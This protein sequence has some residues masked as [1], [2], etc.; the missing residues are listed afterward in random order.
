MVNDIQFCRV[1][2]SVCSCGVELGL[3]QTE[4]EFRLLEMNNGFFTGD[5]IQISS[6]LDEMEI[7]KICCRKT[8]FCSPVYIVSSMDVGKFK[9]H[10]DTEVISNDEDE[11]IIHE[12]LI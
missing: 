5:D 11:L 8:V 6:I 4:I 1:I 7:T 12:K 2:N 9:Y 10:K 3:L